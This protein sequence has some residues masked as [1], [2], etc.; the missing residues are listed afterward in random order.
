MASAIAQVSTGLMSRQ[1]RRAT[2]AFTLLEVVLV[3]VIVAI[4]AALAAPRYFSSLQSYRA[5]LS[6]KRIA[7]DLAMARNNAWSAGARRTVQFTA[8]SNSYAVGSIRG[9]DQATDD[10][11]VCLDSGPYHANIWQVDFEG[12]AAVTFDGYGL[13]DRGGSVIV[14]VGDHQK[15]VVLDRASGKVS[16]Q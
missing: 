8:D 13:P 4:V 12:E 10:Y 15:T 9:L 2:Q 3:V 16:V 11:S 7:A 6:A 5:D 1:R 14:R